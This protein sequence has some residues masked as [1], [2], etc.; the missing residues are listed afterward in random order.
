MAIAYR[1]VCVL[2]YIHRGYDFV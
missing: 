2:L 1:T